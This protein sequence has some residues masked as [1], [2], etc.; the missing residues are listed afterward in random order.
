MSQRRILALCT[1]LDQFDGVVQSAETLSKRYGAGVTLLYV[2]EEGLFELPLFS[3]GDGSIES[4]REHLQESVRQMGHEDWAVLV[5]ENDIVDHAVIESKR[6]KSFLVVSDDHEEIDELVRKIETT[7]F[8]LKKGAVHE[9]GRV[10]LALDSAYTTEKGIDFVLEF[11]KGAKVFCYLDYQLIVSMADPGLDPVVGAMTPDVLMA[12]E[13][14][15]IDAR[16]E[17]FQQLCKEK[18]LKGEFELGE[19]GLVRDILQKREAA[20]AELLAIAAEDRDTLLAEAARQ[21]A[22]ESPVDVL[23]H[24][25]QL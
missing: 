12:E 11:A 3:E 24:Y 9:Y 21:I 7:L 4:V 17:S 6:E 1:E 13:T 2:Q 8:V 25:N 18:G 22:Q 10:L 19:H 20:E 16:R 5:Y 14:E 15:V 23:I